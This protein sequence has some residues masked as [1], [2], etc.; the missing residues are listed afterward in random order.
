MC[1]CCC[2]IHSIKLTPAQPSGAK[3]AE[4]HLTPDIMRVMRTATRLIVSP[5]DAVDRLMQR[6]LLSLIQ[7][8][9]SDAAASPPVLKQRIFS[10]DPG[11]RFV[12]R[13]CAACGTITPSARRCACLSGVYYCGKDCQRRDW[14]EHRKICATVSSHGL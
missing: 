12:G 11:E 5:A 1:R 3:I 9:N 4:L 8:Y 14:R 13:V 10:M 6:T 2:E 7:F